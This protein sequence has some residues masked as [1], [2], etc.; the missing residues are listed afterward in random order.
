MA[1]KTQFMSRGRKEKESVM[2]T[3]DEWGEKREENDFSS[4][5]Y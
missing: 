4:F 1:L 2:S 5:D 3:A